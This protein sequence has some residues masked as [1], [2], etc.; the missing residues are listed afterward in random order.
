MSLLEIVGYDTDSSYE[1]LMQ[2]TI[3]NDKNH[4]S[5]GGQTVTSN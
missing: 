1:K 5:V 2:L 4:I 3:S